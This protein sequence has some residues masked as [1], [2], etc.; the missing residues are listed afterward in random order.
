MSKLMLQKELNGEQQ[1][2]IIHWIGTRAH[3]V[4]ELVDQ[5]KLRSIEELPP[6]KE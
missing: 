1:A 2:Q 3:P 6:D 5:A 4:A